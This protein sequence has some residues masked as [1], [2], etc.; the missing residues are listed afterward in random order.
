[1]IWYD[2]E[3]DSPRTQIQVWEKVLVAYIMSFRLFLKE[4]IV[5]TLGIIF[6]DED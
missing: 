2:N 5:I 3:G 4:T 6:K 1:M